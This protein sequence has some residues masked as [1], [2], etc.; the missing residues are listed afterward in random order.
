MPTTQR[1]VGFFVYEGVQLLDVCGPLE[2]FGEAAK[3]GAPYKVLL[4]SPTGTDV[5]SSAGVRL[6]V[7][8]SAWDA[9][10]LDTVVIAGSEQLVMDSQALPEL[11]PA[12]QILA[13][14]SRRVASVC[15]GAFLLAALGMLDSRRAT[16]HWRHTAQLQSQFPAVEVEPDAIFV[17]SGRIF[18]SAGVSAGLDLALALVEEDYGSDLAR[19]VARE[20]VV[21]MQRPGGQSQ[22][23]VGTGV[24][25]A[26]TPAIRLIMDGILLEPASDHRA[27]VLARRANMSE[28]HLRRLFN[29]EL[30]ITPGNFV[31]QVRLERARTFLEAGSSVSNAA[32]GSG[33]GSDETLRRVFAGTYGTTPSEYRRRFATTVRSEDSG[34]RRS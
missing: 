22:F 1:T 30:G 32:M 15:I 20:L 18:T 2:V 13:G 12:V 19:D 23:S 28:R 21:F 16:T 34:I 26:R 27:G 4:F 25:A 31:E 11:A 6:C 14:G 5:R 8:S 29:S 9:P 17:K 7:D 33:L 24:P 3:R 10:A